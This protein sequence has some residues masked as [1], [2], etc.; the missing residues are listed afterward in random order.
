MLLFL[1]LKSKKYDKEER[2]ASQ[3]SAYSLQFFEKSK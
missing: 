2:M 1:T 3:E